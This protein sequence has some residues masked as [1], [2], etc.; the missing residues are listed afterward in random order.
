[1][2]VNKSHCGAARRSNEY[3]GA[4]TDDY[5]YRHASRQRWRSETSWWDRSIHARVHARD[6]WICIYLYTPA[7][8][9]VVELLLA[10]FSLK[11]VRS[12]PVCFSD[13]F[14][15]FVFFFFAFNRCR[16]APS[17]CFCT[18]ISL[19]RKGTLSVASSFG[20]TIGGKLLNVTFFFFCFRLHTAV[21]THHERE[22]QKRVPRKS[23]YAG[24]RSE[25]HFCSLTW[26]LCLYLWHSVD[27]YKR[28]KRN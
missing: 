23:K 2:K 26:P 7:P 17:F 14:Y 6:I 19:P 15:L 5:N 27:I 25:K 20:Y 4:R 16:T 9:S 24:M 1:M 22:E 18:S 12:L 11:C 28:G 8:A 13:A 21:M 10:Y 3:T